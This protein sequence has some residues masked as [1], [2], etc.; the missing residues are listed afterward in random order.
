MRRKQK[1]KRKKINPAKEI[2]RL[3]TENPD[4]PIIPVVRGAVCGNKYDAWM[5]SIIRV[6]TDEYVYPRKDSANYNAVPAIIRSEGD[7]YGTLETM[8]TWEE[9]DKLPES[10]KECRK[11]YD[12]LPWKR[13]IVIY[14]GLSE[15]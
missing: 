6:M 2:L 7:V 13:A 3:I 4:A 14:I 10:M 5:G 11:I 9:Y 8:L 12:A 15:E 1:Q